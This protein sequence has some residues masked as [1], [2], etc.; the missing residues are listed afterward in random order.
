M[1]EYDYND[2]EILAKG[3]YEY[4]PLSISEV[5]SELN[6]LHNE[7]ERLREALKFYAP[8]ERCE[9]EGDEPHTDNDVCGPAGCSACKG[10]GQGFDKGRRAADAL[11][12]KEGEG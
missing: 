6:R 9:G 2:N 3:P 8:C 5:C 7:N 1:S 11:V 4:E 10:M 12:S